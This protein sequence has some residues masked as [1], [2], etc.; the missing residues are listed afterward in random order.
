MANVW[1]TNQRTAVK[2]FR[3]S[4]PFE[5]EHAAYQRLSERGI[6]EIRGHQVPQLIRLDHELLAIEMTIVERPFLLDFGSAYLDLAAPEF[7]EEIMQEWLARKMDEFGPNWSRA[8]SILVALRE[9]GIHMTD[10]HPGNIGFV[11]EYAGGGS[12]SD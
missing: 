7:P 2:V 3:R 4:E 5:R 1:Q 11:E 10:V 9:L 8:A 12:S 6:I